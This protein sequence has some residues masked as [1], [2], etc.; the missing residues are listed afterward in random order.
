[1]K[2]EW[3]REFGVV[4]RSGKS[5][6]PAVAAAITKIKGGDDSHWF[7]VKTPNALVYRTLLNR[8]FERNEIVG[9]P[10]DLPE[11]DGRFNV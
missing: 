8:A 1:M 7:R 6:S 11:P 3:N 4:L 5:R 2:Q 9:M 10:N